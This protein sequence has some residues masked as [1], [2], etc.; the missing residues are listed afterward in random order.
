[1][2][3]KNGEWRFA[4]LYLT[5]ERP[6][7]EPY[8]LSAWLRSDRDGQVVRCG[9][10]RPVTPAS[11]SRASGG[12]TAC[13]SR[14]RRSGHAG[15]PFHGRV[16]DHGADW[17][18]SSSN[19]GGPR[20]TSNLAA[21]AGA[22]SIRRS[23]PLHGV[24]MKRIGC[25]AGLLLLAAGWA[26]ARIVYEAGTRTVVVSDFPES[27]LTRLEALARADRANGWGLLDYAP[28]AQTWTLRANL[29]VGLA[30]ACRTWLRIG[31][32]ARPARAWSSTARWSCAPTSWSVRTTA[33]RRSGS[34]A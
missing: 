29:Q 21:S 2:I 16:A 13:R 1:M 32:P 33:T 18:P 30:T 3:S 28:D 5:I 23:R 19:A 17:T 12:A 20:R 7:P 14:R 11:R 31:C 27:L 22:L 24:V 34:T 10:A 25:A 6:A 15:H 4:Y 8:V 9:R 26:A